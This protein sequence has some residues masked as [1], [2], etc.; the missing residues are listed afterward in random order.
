MFEKSFYTPPETFGLRLSAVM[1]GFIYHWLTDPAL[2][3]I[4]I[5]RSVKDTCA[6]ARYLDFHSVKILP[7]N[8]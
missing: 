2:D 5:L 7:P 4:A 6:E 8:T 3:V 1:P